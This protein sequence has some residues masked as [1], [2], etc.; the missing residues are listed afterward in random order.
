MRKQAVVRVALDWSRLLGFD[1]IA[2]L[3]AGVKPMPKNVLLA[4]VGSSKSGVKVG[5]KLSAV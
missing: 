4:K 2:K 1:Q 3:Q 5:L